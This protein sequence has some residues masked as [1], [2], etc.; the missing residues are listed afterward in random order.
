MTIKIDKIGSHGK[1]RIVSYGHD[2]EI[3]VPTIKDGFVKSEY[4]YDKIK[5]LIHSPYPLSKE[6]YDAKTIKDTKAAFQLAIPQLVHDLIY[7]VEA[8]KHAT[9]LIFEQLQIL[10]VDLAELR[11][12]TK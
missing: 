3:Q 11:T 10:E 6:E 5:G 7:Q 12:T 9:T 8:L 2:Y 1:A 4:H